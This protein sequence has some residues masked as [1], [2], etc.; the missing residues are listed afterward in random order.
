MKTIDLKDGRT[1]VIRKAVSSD[2]GAMLRYIDIIC[3]ETDN[4]TFG[5]GEFNIPIEEEE[6]IIDSM[7][8][9]DNSLFLVAEINGEI[10]GNLS[11]NG[12][13]RKRT[14]HAGEFGVSVSQ[15]HW[16]LGLGRALIEYLIEWAKMSGIIRKIN[17]RVRTDNDNA[18]KLYKSLGFETEGRL[19][20]DFIINNEFIDC[21]EMGLCID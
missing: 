13:K 17:L 14:R 18:I 16:G 12:G 5:A 21:Y 7:N 11:F 19:T 2:G 1:A 15:D 4:L 8:K 3:R 10:V 9:V 20:R 6:K